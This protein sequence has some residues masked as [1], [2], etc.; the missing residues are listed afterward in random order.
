MSRDSDLPQQQPSPD[1]LAPVIL[2]LTADPD[3]A[4]IVPPPL[5][6][7]KKEE[8]QPSQLDL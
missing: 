3:V 6:E 2:E 8:L 4:S 7:T 5:E 1:Q